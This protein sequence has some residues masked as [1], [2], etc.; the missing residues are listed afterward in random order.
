MDKVLQTGLS[1]G[2]STTAG[3]HSNK[4][5]RPSREHDGKNVLPSSFVPDAR[6]RVTFP[7]AKEPAVQASHISIG[8]WP[9][10]DKATWHWSEDELPA[11]RAAW[12]ELYGAGINF[13][14]TAQ[15]YG[16]GESERLVGELV[17]GL[18]RDSY[19]V[20]TKF[21]ASPA[22]VGNYLH[23]SDE[24]VRALRD[25]LARLK[26]DYVDVYLVH[27]PTHPQSV[28]TVAKGM[29]KCVE[30]GLARAVGV[31]NYDN[32]DVLKMRDELAKYDVPLATNQVEFSV[33]R[34]YP[35]IHGEIAAC[36][37]NGMVFQGY[38]SLAQGKL[39]GKYTAENPPPKTY[40]FSQ[41][42]MEEIEPA[43]EVLEKIAE[44]RGKSAA[45]V[46]LNYTLSKGSLPVV[47][48]RN[49]EQAKQAIEALGW[50]LDQAEI[51][52]IDKVSI[53]GTTT[54]LWQQ[55]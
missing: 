30:E 44:K 32:D 39:S 1:A 40:R 3:F 13:I 14:D 46:A 20:Q 23:P 5:I 12:K 2:M 52:E 29:A 36:R 55:G 16:D 17:A 28:E 22:G 27:G 37:D 11:V 38:S 18:P 31:A 26:L 15:V 53:E 47:G 7:T 10:G 50:R 51:E 25:S 4:P 48:I 21:F 49:V 9:W 54:V 43:L 34:R 35:E 41:Y 6:S 42:P 45:A 8:A 19:V 24:P 33:L